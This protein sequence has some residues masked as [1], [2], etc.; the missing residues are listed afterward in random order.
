VTEEGELVD[1]QSVISMPLANQRCVLPKFDRSPT[2]PFLRQVDASGKKWIIVTDLDGEPVFVLD[3]H[4]F[5]RDA[6]FDQLESNPGAYWHRPVIVRDLQTKLGD[7]IGRMTVS[8]ERPDDDVIDND[9]ILVWGAQ[10]RIITGADL[11]GRLLRD[12]VTVDAR[13]GTPA[14]NEGAKIAGQ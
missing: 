10:K 12:I 6:L 9:L 11:L 14:A 8:P 3:S 2:D 1:A 4:Y 7:V 5:L 13:Q